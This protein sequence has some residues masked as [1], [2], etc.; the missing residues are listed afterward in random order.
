LSVAEQVC[1]SERMQITQVFKK[2]IAARNGK[3]FDS[4]K[5]I[6]EYIG[7]QT[8]TTSDSKNA[9]MLER[10]VALGIV[11]MDY[12]GHKYQL[13]VNGNETDGVDGTMACG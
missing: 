5:Q 9:G 2:V 10:A 4:K 7:A 12:D 11:Q 1:E 6:H 3:L 8:A 13:R